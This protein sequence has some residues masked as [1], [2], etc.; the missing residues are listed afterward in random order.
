[1]RYR[2]IGCLTGTSSSLPRIQR[3]DRILGSNSEHRQHRDG[4]RAQNVL[5]GDFSCPGEQKRRVGYSINL[6]E[7][8]SST[9]FEPL[10]EI[11]SVLHMS[12]L[13]LSLTGSGCLTLNPFIHHSRYSS[14]HLA[15]RKPSSIAD[16]N[17][18]T[19]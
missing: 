16:G 19:A 9:L 10:S 15:T 14:N 18:K 13:A 1:M 4:E 12:V 8:R 7:K 6:I 17:A 3:I 11:N 2:E 5:L